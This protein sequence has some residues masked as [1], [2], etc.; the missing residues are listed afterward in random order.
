MTSWQQF[1]K[2]YNF[3]SGHQYFMV[4]FKLIKFSLSSIN[5]VILSLFYFILIILKIDDSWI[6]ENLMRDRCIKC[7]DMRSFFPPPSVEPLALSFGYVSFNH[8]LWLFSFLWFS[9]YYGAWVPFWF[10]CFLSLD[11]SFSR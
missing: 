6:Y 5:H 4:H 9:Y 1:H 11:V 2:F 7:G 8:S 3:G 10:F